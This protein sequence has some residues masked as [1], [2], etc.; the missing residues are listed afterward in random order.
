MKRDLSVI[1]KELFP[2]AVQ[3]TYEQLLHSY[4]TDG[5]PNINPWPALNEAVSKYTASVLNIV[6]NKN[7]WKAADGVIFADFRNFLTV[8][9]EFFPIYE[10]DA[11]IPYMDIGAWNHANGKKIVQLLVR[12]IFYLNYTGMNIQD[13]AF[14][15]ETSFSPEIIRIFLR[16][17]E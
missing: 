15:K 16:L 9:D 2:G 13:T 1:A 3:N 11:G 14:V 7:N 10:T 6:E 5:K 12:E 8:F 4:G 17:P